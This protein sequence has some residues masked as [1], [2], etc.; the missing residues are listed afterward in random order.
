MSAALLLGVLPAERMPEA[1]RLVRDLLPSTYGVEAFARTFGP[2]PTVARVV[3]DSAVA[4][5]SRALAG[6]RDLG[7]PQGGRPVT[8]RTAGPGTM[9]GERNL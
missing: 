2:H 8:H 4:G 6:R 5:A 3:G 9:R 1:V 7:V